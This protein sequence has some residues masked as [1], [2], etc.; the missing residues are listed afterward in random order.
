[1]LQF[2]GG[3]KMCLKMLVAC[4]YYCPMNR[5]CIRDYSLQGEARGLWSIRGLQ[6]WVCCLQRGKDR[7]WEMGHLRV[8]EASVSCPEW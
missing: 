8:G 2:P 5:K 6:V 1:M 7:K 4:I 3:I